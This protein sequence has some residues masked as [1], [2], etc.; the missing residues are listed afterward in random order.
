MFSAVVFTAG[1]SGS[2]LVI[3]NLSTYFKTPKRHW[4][5]N[6]FKY[7]VVHSHNPLYRPPNDNFI[8]IIN[9]RKD[10]FAAMISMLITVRTNEFMHYSN[11][12]IDPFEI[13]KDEFIG[14]YNYFKCFYKSI[15]LTGFKKVIEI[16]YEPLIA[17]PKYLFSKF[18]LDQQTVYNLKKSPYDYRELITNLDDIKKLYLEL[19]STNISED[20]LRDF[21]DNIVTDLTNIRNKNTQS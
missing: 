20:Q 8:C 10:E 2:H 17:D 14:M 3:D 21:K 18:D 12:S 19:L 9:T 1:R 16:E 15:C 7:G 13:S 11:K 5:D 4:W 6:S